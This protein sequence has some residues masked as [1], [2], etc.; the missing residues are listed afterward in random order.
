M[1][2]AQS[3]DV[4]QLSMRL[5]TTDTGRRHGSLVTLLAVLA[6]LF[7]VKR[8]VSV[9]RIVTIFAQCCG[10][11]P[12][13]LPPMCT[14]NR[15]WDQ[16]VELTRLRAATYDQ[17]SSGREA[18]GVNTARKSRAGDTSLG[19]G[20]SSAME[21]TK[22]TTG[23]D[24]QANQPLFYSVRPKTKQP[25]TDIRGI[26]VKL[27]TAKDIAPRPHPSSSIASID[28]VERGHVTGWAC[29]RS[30]S[31]LTRSSAH[32]YALVDDTVVA[33]VDV[34]D[35][36][37][38]QDVPSDISVI[39]AESSEP[40]NNAGSSEERNAKVFKFDIDLPPLPVGIHNLRVLIEDDGVGKSLDS[41]SPSDT[42]DPTGSVNSSSITSSHAQDGPKSS[43]IEAFHSPLRFEESVNELSMAAIIKRK[44][45]IITH[46]NNL[47]TKLW[48]EVHT[49]LPWRRYEADALD[50][51]IDTL[52]DGSKEP[53]L[54]AF[55]IVRSDAV[56]QDHRNAIRN[57]W[58]KTLKENNM[59]ASFFVETQYSGPHKD[60]LDKE[61]KDHPDITPMSLGPEKS[62]E[63]DRVL[64]A[65]HHAVK[66]H[67]AL[68]YFLVSDGMLVVPSNLQKYLKKKAVEGNVFMG[69]MKSGGIVTDDDK[70][71]YEPQHWRFGDGKD[72]VYPQHA[73]SAMFGFS[74]LVARHLARSKEVLQ[75][76]AHPDTTIGT[77]MLGLN[78][79]YDNNDDFCADWRLCMA[80][81]KP[82]GAKDPA[83]DGICQAQDMDQSWKV[84]S[85]DS[86]S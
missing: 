37:R 43:L 4:Q 13:I 62:E 70:G 47:L 10:S 3:R 5:K 27:P 52:G 57:T 71:W 72:K 2:H 40:D 63:V 23:C 84:C 41:S 75:R 6:S 39:C 60:A 77:W 83:C 1:K 7:V 17:V 18:R 80:N 56:R 22:A 15:L 19:S 82:M 21:D 34:A 54:L 74:R 67:D 55:I 11:S 32:I 86:S 24:R 25:V 49:Q 68:F 73:R 48:N 61:M 12:C 59:M 8:Y 29:H 14:K 51:P 38:D 20:M 28:S 53:D 42:Q 66:H 85:K 36:Y 50:I 81:R 76:Y 64:Y 45:E 44:D 9:R 65:L 16:H 31:A 78:V 79:E 58:W 35:T 46:R 69:C 26:N 30:S 33:S